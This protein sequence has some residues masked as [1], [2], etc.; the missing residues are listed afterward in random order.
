MPGRCKKGGHPRLSPFRGGD[1]YVDVPRFRSR[2]LVWLS[3]IV[4][5][6]AAGSWWM[7]RRHGLV[8]DQPPGRL[9]TAI[10]RRL[11]VL[12]IPSSQRQQ[13]S[14]LA[15]DARAWRDGADHFQEHCATCH[16]NDGRGGSAI[17]KKMF[18]P[19]PDLADPGIQAMSDGALFAIISNGVRWTGMPA[20][21]QEHNADETW[22]LVA[23]VR[24]VPGLDP[25]ELMPSPAHQADPGASAGAAP[26]AVA[27]DGTAFTPAEVT[28]AVG[29]TVTWTNKDPFPHNVTSGRGHFHSQD[30]PAGGRWAFTPRA[31]GRFDYVCTL[32]PGM[33]GTLV[34]QPKPSKRSNE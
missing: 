25:R 13:K 19:V 9:E 27:M 34:V 6:A 22:K 29:T 11:V 7:L 1:L 18:P 2:L 33:H 16:G 20:F 26:G 23:F 14:P 24:R 15:G 10:A 5:A 8:S 21:R 32:H 4:V 28:V 17:A 31:A 3:L 30:V 12:S